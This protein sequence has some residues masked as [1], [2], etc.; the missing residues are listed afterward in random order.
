MQDPTLRLGLFPYLALI[1]LLCGA[2]YVAATNLGS[3]LAIFIAIVVLQ[4]AKTP[5]AAARARDLG[6]DGDEAV[7]ALL[8]LANLALLRKLIA[9]TPDESIRQARQSVHAGESTAWELAR[10][11][12]QASGKAPWVL[13]LCMLV[14]AGDAAITEG[15]VASLPA[16][17]AADPAS[18]QTATTGLAG[19][20]G[21]LTAWTL[22]QAA[23]GASTTRMR[24][25]AAVLVLAGGLGFAVSESFVPAIAAAAVLV[26][27]L[28]GKGRPAPPRRS[29]LPTVLL[30]LFVFG[31]VVSSS[32]ASMAGSRDATQA[33]M[34]MLVFSGFAVWPVFAIA[35][36]VAAFAT[37]AAGQAVLRGD[38]PGPGRAREATVRLFDD[39]AVHAGVRYVISIGLQCFILPGLMYATRYA[40]MDQ[41][42][43][44]EPGS[45]SYE[46]SS[47]LS[48]NHRGR[49][50]RVLLLVGLLPSLLT[51][52]LNLI[53]LGDFSKLTVLLA[54]PF[55]ASSWTMVAGGAAYG[56]SF[57]WFELAMV[58]MYAER[59]ATTSTAAAGPA[60]ASEPAPAE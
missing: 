15:I 40:M 56:L 50:L 23:R 16:I 53:D 4:V 10:F 22:A 30:P 52:G 36:A 57:A 35:G 48:R 8:P 14:G 31:T 7:L 37:H 21:L 49:I 27:A 33:H 1:A 29:W 38:A 34:F 11:G 43:R 12:M 42:L 51:L 55:A 3:D 58:K 19:T 20:A 32:A 13:A 5:V 26:A 2:Q 60:P 28:M 47:E 9:G 18:L 17:A 25:I 59:I 54:D 46:R 45:A 24:G 41:V 39:M 6:Y 44:E